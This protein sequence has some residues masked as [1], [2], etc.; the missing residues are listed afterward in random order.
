[1]LSASLLAAA[2]AACQQRA[3]DGKTADAFTTSTSRTPDNAP[4]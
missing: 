4:D 2:D 1:L 3:H